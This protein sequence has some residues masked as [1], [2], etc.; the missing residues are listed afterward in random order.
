MQMHFFPS[1]LPSPSGKCPRGFS[2]DIVFCLFLPLHVELYSPCCPR[3]TLHPSTDFHIL[4]AYV[5]AIFNNEIS[6]ATR[7]RRS[8]PSCSRARIGAALIKNVKSRSARGDTTGG[9]PLRRV[10]AV[11][12]G[13][14]D[15]S[16]KESKNGRHESRAC[17]ESST[18]TKRAL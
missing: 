9:F 12:S 8:S 13:S 10:S 4:F 3:P 7:G 14:H 17:G 6:P 5:V 16:R 2:F 1:L 18:A 11:A 15:K